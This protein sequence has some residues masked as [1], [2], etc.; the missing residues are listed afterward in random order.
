MKEYHTFLF[1]VTHD[2]VKVDETFHTTVPKHYSIM[3]TFTDEDFKQSDAV[4]TAFYRACEE[5]KKKLLE[6]QMYHK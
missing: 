6:D 2:V 3:V 5:Y 1:N 4:N